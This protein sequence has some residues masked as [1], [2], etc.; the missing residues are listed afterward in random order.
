M[1][2]NNAWQ[3]SFWINIVNIHIFQAKLFF[4][5]QFF[6]K[7]KRIG[8]K[9]LQQIEVLIMLIRVFRVYGSVDNGDACFF[10]K[11]KCTWYNISVQ[12]ERYKYTCSIQYRRVNGKNR[13]GTFK[14]NSKLPHLQLPFV[15]EV[16]LRVK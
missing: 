7:K 8:F 15:E 16:F 1:W 11:L 4:K 9:I 14:R 10:L 6:I 13:L 5:K 12:I 2:K 3:K